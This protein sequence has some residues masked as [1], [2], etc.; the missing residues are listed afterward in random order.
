MAKGGEAEKSNRTGR[1]A[2]ERARQ[3]IEDQRR[4]RVRRQQLIAAAVGVG[5]VAVVV[6]VMV[7]VKLTSSDDTAPTAAPTGQAAADVVRTVTTVPAGVLDQVGKGK[8]NAL[9]KAVT[10]LAALTADGK[11]AV[12]YIG[13][14]Y[15]PFCASQ[16]WAVVVALSRFGT[17]TNLGLT[18]SAS[19]DVFPNTATL[20][21]HGS[22]YTSQVLAFQGVETAGNERKG[23]GY[24]PLDSLTQQQH[25][26]IT[27]VN[28]PPYV[29]KDAAGSIPFL[30]IGNRYVISGGSFSP[31]LLKGRSAA[32]IAAEL[33]R[34]DSAITRAVVGAAN[35]I[36]TAICKI[37]NDQP[38]EV[39]TGSAAK[40]YAGS[41][42]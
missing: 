38:A 36:T 28:A 1:A 3:V 35:A 22:S 20:T 42:G 27:T 33:S 10:G 19:D 8:V 21:F 32:E 4:Q 37:T 23:N 18:H 14:E 9:P 31:G 17:F 24:A 2:Q 5:L 15:C 29:P 34:P 26:L 25:Q 30:D 41:L 6:A 39:C 40:A 7:F 11:P 12:V 16:R 13:A